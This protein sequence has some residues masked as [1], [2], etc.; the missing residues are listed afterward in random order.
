[1]FLATLP[2]L[3]SNT[4]SAIANNSTG[5]VAYMVS[6]NSADL[7]KRLVLLHSGSRWRGRACISSKGTI[8]LAG[9]VHA[10][11]EARPTDEHCP[12]EF[13]LRAIGVDVSQTQC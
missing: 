11:P 1:M 4:Y 7:G 5:S 3:L 8:G 9:N 12:H 10:A 6:Q 13:A 2:Q